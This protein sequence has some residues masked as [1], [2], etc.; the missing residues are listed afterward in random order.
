MAQQ[1]KES[2]IERQI[3]LYLR[4]IGWIAIKHRSTGRFTHG[5]LISLPKDELGVSD[6][7]AVDK[8]GIA[9]FLEIKTPKGKQSDNQIAFENLV[10]QHN[11]NYA[12]LRSLNDAKLYAEKMS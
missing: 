10:K 1:V 7:I 8:K 5:R 12:V 11:S 6:I 9:H 4:S 2:L 3:I